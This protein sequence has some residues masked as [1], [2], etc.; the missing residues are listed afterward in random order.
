MFEKGLSEGVSQPLRDSVADRGAEDAF[1]ERK[2]HLDEIA[3]SSVPDQRSTPSKSSKPRTLVSALKA[4]VPD[5]IQQESRE[6]KSLPEIKF[7]NETEV[8][9]ANGRPKRLTR[10]SKAPVKSLTPEIEKYS[11]KHG[12][13]EPWD[14]PVVYPGRDKTIRS[15]KQVSVEFDDLLRLDE[16]EWFNDSL[17]EYCLLCYQQQYQMQAKKVYFFSNFFYSK[18]V[19][20]P[21]RNIDYEAVRR[22]VKDDIFTYDFVVVPVCENA[23]WYLVLICN[24]SRLERRLADDDGDLVEGVKTEILEHDG[25]IEKPATNVVPEDTANKAELQTRQ[26]DLGES[27]DRS[28]GHPENKVSEDE[29]AMSLVGTTAQDMKKVSG[30]TDSANADSISDNQTKGTA[31]PGTKTKGKRHSMVRKYAPDTPAIAILDSMPM[32]AKHGNTVNAL[33]D[34]LVAEANAKRGMAIKRESLQGMHITRGIPMQDNFSDCGLFLCRYVGELLK[35]PEGFSSKLFGG[36]LDKIDWGSWD[37]NEVRNT[38]RSELQVLAAEQSKQRKDAKAEKRK[39][40][41]AALPN[42]S[43]ETATEASAV[44]PDT[45]T[46]LPPSHLTKASSPVKMSSPTRAPINLEDVAVVGRPANL[47]DPPRSPTR[48]PS[49]VLESPSTP[50]ES[51]N[52][53]RVG[54][55]DPRFSARSSPAGHSLY[56]AQGR[57]IPIYEDAAQGEVSNREP[58]N[59]MREDSEDVMLHDE[60][61]QEGDVEEPEWRGFDDDEPIDDEQDDD[62][63]NDEE[64][65]YK[66]QLLHAVGSVPGGGKM[67]KDDHTDVDVDESDAVSDAFEGT[68]SFSS[69]A[70][71]SHG[72]PIS[73]GIPAL[74]FV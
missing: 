11:V 53:Q 55:E 35:D 21:G 7:E 69:P 59:S 2:A 22:W 37:T 36:E 26:A 62:E 16:G 10:A 58:R 14:Q 33:K 4:S 3:Q 65:G 17:V 42:V 15:K 13:G 43:L 51:K 32:G 24:L 38:I 48:S 64:Q 9:S 19:A 47:R 23:H 12:L 71:R 50:R 44:P 70:T 61:V 73:P 49:P 45:P 40:K 74:P 72:S 20:K 66:I 46:N 60:Q 6:R 27:L 57:S 34:F 39:L 28:S 31:T 67:V 52:S 5:D 54:S 68:P 41:R 29:D 25:Q 56:F 18:L 8:R 30:L 1:Y 63:Q